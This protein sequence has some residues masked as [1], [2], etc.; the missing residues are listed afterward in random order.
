[1]ENPSGLATGVVHWLLARQLP[2][3]AIRGEDGRASP[4]DH[5]A[6][7]FAALAMAL[8]ASR[9]RRSDLWGAVTQAIGYTLAL[10]PAMRR[11]QEFNSLALLML[12]ACVR[13]TD[14]AP[15]DLRAALEAAIRDPAFLY[16]GERTVS[17]N[18]LAMRA[19]CFLMA[20]RLLSDERCRLR[21]EAL[22][23]ETL[24]RQLPDG[25]FVDYPGDV[26][27]EFATPL[28]YHAKTCAML[29][30]AADYT[31]R[32]TVA[33]AVIRG[34]QALTALMSP[35]GECL[36]FGRS[37]N[38][39]FGLAATYYA[40]RTVGAWEPTGP[41]A[42][43]ADR[44]WPGIA[45]RRESDGHLRLTPDRDE[46]RRSGWD[47]YYHTEVYN[48]YAAALLLDAPPGPVAQPPGRLAQEPCSHQYDAGLVAFRGPQFFAAFT[49]RGQCVLDGSSLFS[50][51]RYTGLQPQLFELAGVPQVPEPPLLWRG[52]TTKAEAVSPRHTGFTPYIT[53][54]GRDHCGRVFER[55]FV[56]G[57]ARWFMIWGRGPAMSLTLPP[58]A[59]RLLRRL[60]GRL[61]G[62]GDLA[63]TPRRLPGLSLVR[64]ILIFPEHQALL[65]V[66]GY[67]GRW[68]RGA[69]WNGP[70][71]RLL[72]EA[73]VSVTGLLGPDLRQMPGT[74]PTSRGEATLWAGAPTSAPEAGCVQAYVCGPRE[75]RVSVEPAYESE[76]HICIEGTWLCLDLLKGDLSQ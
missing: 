65:F 6:H 8:V 5:Y 44:L 67:Q 3:G 46:A 57:S 20:A 56:R 29:C 60:R 27:T 17:N 21:G 64:A 30:M 33:P 53:W 52:P 2:S 48:A 58:R 38:S 18:W 74:A 1:V 23:R 45:E 51:M 54:R 73:I 47:V 34:L 61:T 26:R 68:P 7:A 39:L 63:F 75:L 4:A 19:V 25:I 35:H 14:A 42:A 62:E 31:E 15:H 37:C 36:Y 71:A 28:T 50:D 76:L 59:V 72:P 43:E 49:T 32:E 9:E 13:D 11:E 41:W 10:P 12:T 16:D 69:V 22:V 24:G 70:N 40:L 55:A 66:D